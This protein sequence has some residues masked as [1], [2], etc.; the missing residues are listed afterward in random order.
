[1]FITNIIYLFCAKIKKKLILFEKYKNINNFAQFICGKI[2]LIAT[3]E[4]NA[5]AISLSLST[6]FFYYIVTVI[7]L[8]I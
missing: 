3:T 1:M 5:K 7:N 2:W 4:K 6:A 8:N